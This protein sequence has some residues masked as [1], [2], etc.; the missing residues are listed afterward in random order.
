MHLSQNAMQLKNAWLA[1]E[2][3]KVKFGTCGVVC[4][5]YVGCLSPLMLNCYFAVIRWTFLNMACNFKR[6]GCGD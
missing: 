4:N 2:G 5:M 1:V 3:N 6:A